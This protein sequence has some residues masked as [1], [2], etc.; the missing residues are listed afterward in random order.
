MTNDQLQGFPLSPQQLHLWELLRSGAA[1]TYRAAWAARIE[2]ALE[3]GVLRRAVEASVAR[4]EI[5]RTS[6]RRLPGMTVPVQVI[7]DRPAVDFA[8][9]DLRAV[10]P[11]QQAHELRRLDERRAESLDLDRGPVLRVRLATLAHDRHRLSFDLPALCA[12]TASLLN[13]A[14]EVLTA[15]A[16]GGE[17]R[18]NAEEVVQYADVAAWENDLLESEDTE[19]GRLLWQRRDFAASAHPTLPYEVPGT[20]SGPFAPAVERVGLA[21][22]TAAAVERLARER[23]IAP[24]A[25][26]LAAFHALLARLAEAA[27]VT[28]GADFAGRKFADLERSLGLF[29]RSLPITVGTEPETGFWELASRVAAGL[30]AVAACEEYF[31]WSL[32]PGWGDG[33]E[34]PWLPWAF[35]DEERQPRSEVGGLVVVEEELNACSDRFTALLAVVRRDGRLDLELRHD[36]KRLRSEAARCLLGQYRALLAAAV[37]RSDTPLRDLPLASGEERAAM[38]DRLNRTSVDLGPPLCLHELVERQARATPERVAVTCGGAALTYLELDRR[39]DRLAE[40]LRRRGVAAEDRVA[41][42]LD[43]SLEMVVA[44]VGILKAGGAYV[45]LDVGQP[46]KRLELLLADVAPRALVTA[47]ALA[48]RLPP[49]EPGRLLLVDA[50]GASQALSGPASRHSDV[51]RLAYV[52]YTSGSTGRPKGVMVSHR[53]IVNRLLWMQRELPLEAKDR[54]LHKTPISF[55]ASIWEIFVP[56]LAGATVVVAAPDAHRDTGELAAAIAEEG[57]TVL[58]LV[59]TLLAAFLDEPRLAGGALRRLFAG[60]ERL[61]AALRD[62]AFERLEAVELHNLYGPTEAAIDASHWHCVR[63]DGDVA[64]PIGRPID[65]LRLYV[66]DAGGRPV[67]VG[68]PGELHI[69]GAGLAR[70]YLG[71]PGLSAERFVPDPFAGV[72]GARMYRTGDRGRIRPD[73]AIEFLGRLDGQV[74]VRGMRVEPGEVEAVLSAHPRLAAAVVMAREGAAGHLQLAAYFVPRPGGRVD[75]AELRQYLAERLPEALLPAHLV[76][77]EELPVTASGKV[78]RR[79]LPAPETARQGPATGYV[80]PSRETERILAEIWQVLL[81]VERVGVHDN[82]FELGG[83]SIA[84]LQVIG[85]AARQ[86]IRFTVQQMFERPTIARLV[87]VAGSPP[88]PAA[89]PMPVIGEVPLTPIQRAFFALERPGRNH[90]NQ[91]VLLATAPGL[92]PELLGRAFAALLEHHDVLRARFRRHPD[93]RQSVAA[94]AS[95]RQWRHVDLGGL[96]AALRWTDLERQAASFQLG[97]DIEQGPLVGA[98]LWSGGPGEAGRLL[99]VAHHLVVDGVS[100]RILLEDLAT[101]CEQLARGEAVALPP[102]TTSWKQWAERLEEH[103]TSTELRAEASFWLDAIPGPER[104]APLPRDL[105]GG[106][107]DDTVA[108]ADRVDVVLG[109]AE[110][111]DLLRR[112]PGAYRARLDE[113]LLTAL[114]R[115][116]ERWSGADGVL[117]EREGHGREAISSD[118]DLSRTVGWFTAVHPVWLEGVASCAPAAAVRVV[119]ERLRAVPGGGLGYG[120]LRYLGPEETRRRLGELP[121]PEVVFNYLGRL[122][123]ALPASAPFAPASEAR[124]RERGPDNRRDYPFEINVA[125]E[126]GCLRCVWIYSAAAHR[127]QTVEALAGSFRDELSALLDRRLDPVPEALA[128]TDFPLA[129]LDQQALDALLADERPLEDVYPLS[130]LQQGLLFHALHDSGSGIYVQQLTCVI[131]GDLDVE[132]FC[133]SWQTVLD[134]HPTLR[135]EIA[136]VGPERHLQVVRQGVRVPVELRELELAPEEWPEHAAEHLRRERQAGFDLE[137]APLMRIVLFRLAEGVHRLTWS[138]HHLILDGWS[139]PMLLRELFTQYLALRGD[140]AAPALEERRPYRDYVEWLA[141]QDLARAERFWRRSLA[142]FRTPTPLAFDRSVRDPRAVS[143]EHGVV[144]AGLSERA[145]EKFRRLVKEH[146]VTPNTVVQGSWALLLSRYSG[147]QDVLFGA[148]SGGRPPTLAGAERMIG[149]FVNSVPVRIAVDPRAHLVAWLEEIQSQQVKA[150]EY[151]F[152]PLLK[153][154]GWSEVPAGLSL[155]E[156]IMAFENYPVDEVLREQEAAGLTVSDVQFVERTNYPLS[157]SVIPD[158]RLRLRMVFDSGRLD[159]SSVVRMADHLTTLL[160]AMGE[161]PESTLAELSMMPPA[162]RR[163]V[164]AGFPGMPRVV[165]EPVIDGA[166]GHPHREA[167]TSEALLQRVLP[168]DGGVRIVRPDADLR[169]YVLDAEGEPAPVGVP[170]ELHLDGE[171]LGI[172]SLDR[173]APTADRFRP[174]GSSTTPGLRLYA[175]GER[176]RRLPD[177]DLELLGRSAAGV[178][179]HGGPAEPEEVEALLS[180]HPRVR[181]AA[182]V[183][184]EGGVGAGRLRAYVVDSRDDAPT[185]GDGLQVSVLNRN[186]ADLIYREIFEGDSYLRHGIELAD[187]DCVFDVGA[188]IGLF[189]LYVHDRCRG[190]QV[191]AF[192]PVAPVRERLERNVERYGLAVRVL[193][194]GLLDAD[195]EQELVFYPQWSGMSGIHADAAE[196]AAATRAFLRNQVGEALAA[197][198]ETLLA[199]RFEQQRLRCAFRRLSDVVREEGIERIDLL[200]VDVEKSELEVLKGIDEEHWP[201]IDQVVVEAH[202]AGGRS[203]AVVQLLRDEGFEVAVDRGGLLADTGMCNVYAVHPRRRARPAAEHRRLLPRRIEDSM[204]VAAAHGELTRWLLEHGVAAEL[205]LLDALP[206]AASGEVDRRQLAKRDVVPARRAVMPRTPEEVKLSEIWCQVLGLEAVGI[207]DNFIEL[208]GD[209]ILGLQVASRARHAGFQLKTRDIFQY[210]TVAELAQRAPAAEAAPHA[211]EE[212]ESLTPVLTPIQH[213]FFESD[214]PSP[215]HFNQATLLEMKGPLPASDLERALAAVVEHHDALRARFTRDTDASWRPAQASRESMPLVVE[216][217]LAALGD[218]EQ[219]M[220]LVARATR[221]QASLD[222]ERGPLLR[223]VRFDRGAG[224]SALLLVVIHH[225]VVDAV[226]WRILIEDLER[227]LAQLAAGEVVDLPAVVTSYARWSRCLAA[228]VGSGAL[229]GELSYWRRVANEAVASLPAD[230]PEGE[231]AVASAAT[232]KGSLPVEATAA[233]LR[234]VP[235]VY[236]TQV[237]EV[238]LAALG[239]T[240]AAWSGSRRLRLDLER[241]GR[242]EELVAGV[243]LSRTVGW[244]TTVYPLLIE[245][246]AER[247]PGTALKAV[248]EQV[249]GVPERGIGYGLLRYLSP[250][251]EVRRELAAPPSEVSFNYLGQYDAALAESSS[252]ALT[253]G[254]VGP[255]R[256]PEG[257]LEYLLAIDAYVAGGELRTVWTYSSAILEA[258]TVERLVKDFLATLGAL[259]EHCLSPGAGG[260]TP[261]DFPDVDLDQETLDRLLGEVEFEATGGS[262]R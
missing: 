135:T 52:L 262:A 195:G 20:P 177:G 168:S 95:E 144:E 174:N 243:D 235:E 260:Y 121:R 26:L 247:D 149:V 88:A 137:R 66:L 188:N 28:V 51:D 12:D 193:P 46:L 244:F 16:G 164:L 110:T 126:N 218:E 61:T 40:S 48:S 258:A 118:L 82:F 23:R 178:E 93:W 69:G 70:G 50:P 4:H 7:E 85:R 175:T 210:P 105:S 72:V 130:P 143:T 5:L 237:D 63:G 54:L 211:K 21:P 204:L 182:V 200:K 228:H 197:E 25:V 112:A 79:A 42:F 229:D 99:I 246:P 220:E 184:A 169:T 212:P 148:V 208:G 224:R 167:A 74:K 179:R 24:A 255:G 216:E 32:V 39:A 81:G 127:R 86:G 201:R 231:P 191:Y 163:E 55:D 3:G 261:S 19:E 155:F 78:D 11:A 171:A 183:V 227:V 44:L 199:E 71:R 176:A 214:R 147:R 123:R 90:W 245:L 49:Q 107:R 222:L 106:P 111:E 117:I 9:L 139:I 234:R 41:L 129:G 108:S 140:A 158:R 30:D 141:A 253:D 38:V 161:R 136:A 114:A 33:P 113:L 103:A 203:R 89:D 35:G 252:F 213:R 206:R 58:Q 73:G 173:P 17:G 100:W 259:I 131:S 37:G 254:P 236:R 166:D 194:Y 80:A 53:A 185:V 14:A 207:H 128:P 22:E 215:H 31:S 36:P 165:H 62:R 120:L 102:K 87:E 1:G 43:R 156:T 124:G 109:E 232:A 256:A 153:V 134:R 226:S 186:E 160:E 133:R 104:V 145:T 146:R 151:E 96:S 34:E 15:C 221:A 196:D 223:A 45:A 250:R 205:V 249:R 187:G 162:E 92:D 209:S 257:R 132:A 219:S 202:D 240:L 225:L 251:S 172:V 67:A 101:G 75:V 152:A 192:E 13:L 57:I 119:K 242:D 84:S 248:K 241:H 64:V 59:P 83:D 122:D 65:N 157:L 47:S 238:L 125:V 97:L 154:K 68:E 27:E 76:P 180:A 142:G 98:C 189:S 91:S 181:E 6:F 159:R 239:Q 18:E 94:P 170:G 217:D 8:H 60:G 115:V 56:L 138:H 233:L 77:L 10:G 29:A 116:L 198:A 230:H 190:A 150:R 2:G